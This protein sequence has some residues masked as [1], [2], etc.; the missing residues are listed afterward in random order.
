MRNW[1]VYGHE[2]ILGGGD[3]LRP[4]H[5]LLLITFDVVVSHG[6]QSL[7]LGRD[8]VFEYLMLDRIFAQLLL[9][10]FKI[11]LP[12]LERF[13][14]S[15][16]MRLK[17]AD[18]RALLL[19][20]LGRVLQLLMSPL[21]RLLLYAILLKLFLESV[22][23]AHNFLVFFLILSEL[24]IELLFFLILQFHA[25]LDGAQ[26]LGQFSLLPIAFDFEIIVSLSYPLLFD[27]PFV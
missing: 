25:V 8:L 10:G 5:R 22:I 9:F 23:L 17:V 12:L 2:T 20:S 18:L 24:L 11:S 16:L 21:E 7:L 1:W 13:V 4:L 3:E 14:E 6:L 27:I 15:L 19:V 26:L